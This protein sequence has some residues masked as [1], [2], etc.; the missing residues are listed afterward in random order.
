MIRRPP[1]STRT[2]TLFPY[3]TLFRS[4]P[5][6]GPTTLRDIIGDTVD[7][8]IVPF[9]V[10]KPFNEPKYVLSATILNQ[11]GQR[12]AL[13][14]TIQQIRREDISSEERRLGKKYVSK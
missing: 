11:L 2:D 10:G 13:D 4:L 6:V 8:L 5:I 14:E 1:R 9:A 7:K 3:P 12:A